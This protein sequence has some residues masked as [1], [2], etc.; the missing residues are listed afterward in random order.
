MRSPTPPRDLS[1]SFEAEALP[2][3]PRLYLTALRLTGNPHDAEDLLQETY[4]RAFRGYAGFR[5]GTNLMAWLARILRNTFVNS[6][7][8]RQREP[9]TVPDDPITTSR[10]ATAGVEVSAEATV[11][12]ALP[13]PR[14]QEALSTLPDKYRRAVLLY[15]VDGFSYREIAALFDVPVG[16][17]MSRIHRGRRALKERL[18]PPSVVPGLAA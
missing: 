6:Y 7:R 1:G 18:V 13:D 12:D 3:R 17:V 10:S 15:D 16:T 4:L 2:L 9:R 8:K 11:V 5:P 14:L